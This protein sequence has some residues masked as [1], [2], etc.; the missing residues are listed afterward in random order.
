[1]CHIF[2]LKHQYIYSSLNNIVMLF[3]IKLFSIHSTVYS[4]CVTVSI[5]IKNT[6]ISLYHGCCNNQIPPYSSCQTD[7]MGPL[8]GFH[9]V[10]IAWDPYSVPLQCFSQLPGQKWRHHCHYQCPWCTWAEGV[11]RDNL[12]PGGSYLT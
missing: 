9:L 10:L 8:R 6:V 12:A 3:L 7:V 5:F 1:M 2:H 4:D 11:V